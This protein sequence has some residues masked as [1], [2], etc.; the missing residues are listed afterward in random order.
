[1]ERFLA[2]DEEARVVILEEPVFRVALVDAN[3]I[4]LDVETMILLLHFFDL[5]LL[6]GHLIIKSLDIIS[7]FTLDLIELTDSLVNPSAFD[8]RCTE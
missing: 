1:L 6:P 2:L 4:G 3:D 7:Q 8:S 5:L